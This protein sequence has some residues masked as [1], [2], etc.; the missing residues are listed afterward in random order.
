[1]A[2]NITPIFAVTPIVSMVQIVAAN[3][4]RGLSAFTWGS[5]SLGAIGDNT[6]TNRSSP[7]SV[8]GAHLFY[9]TSIINNN[10]LSLKPDGSCWAWGTGS[11]GGNGDNNTVTRS[12]PVSVLGTHVF[13]EIA[14]STN[15]RIALKTDGSTWAWGTNNLGQ[16]GDNTTSNRSSPV[17]VVGAHSFIK[18]SGVGCSYALKTDGSLWS[19]GPFTNGMLGDNLGVSRSSPVSVVGAHSFTAIAAHTNGASALK[20][21]GS[22]WAWGLGTSGQCGD[23]TATDRSSPVSV[24]GAHS[25][26]AIA[27]TSISMTTALK[28]DGS[29]WTWGAATNG[30]LGDNQITSNR[31]SPVSVVGAHSFVA[32]GNSLGL[33][34]DGSL[35]SWGLN[36][37]GQIGDNTTTDRSSPV[38]VVGGYF[39]SNKIS[40]S[41][42]AIGLTIGNQYATLLVGAANGTLVDTIAVCATGTTTGGAVRIFINDS[43]NIALLKE[44]PVSASIPSTSIPA[45]SITIPIGITIESGQSLLATTNNA[46]TLNVIANGATF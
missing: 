34:S 20:S 13:A 5:G 21:D 42:D 8:V 38:S 12:S 46:E 32:I 40:T 7:V 25:F 3:T 15:T 17:S 6:A 43:G 19:W 4:N 1:M 14:I 11:S 18:V 9:K 36:S 30:A 22:C 24:I 23:N 16:A 37:S 10:A 44:I 45:F 41:T 39:F 29:V 33:K 28:A 31:S 27:G 26:T 2:M 35:W